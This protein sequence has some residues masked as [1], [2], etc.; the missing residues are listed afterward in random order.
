[1]GANDL[2]M[3]IGLGVVAELT[4]YFLLTR[5]FKLQA[6]AAAMAIAMLMV[7]IYVPWAIMVW[8]GA[9]VFAIHLAIFLTF[10]YGL[11]LIGSRQG[12]GWHWAP[13]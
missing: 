12:K 10:A 2:I 13:A 3:S 8:P 7:L 5:V 6:K 9:D 1:M 11:G 4:L